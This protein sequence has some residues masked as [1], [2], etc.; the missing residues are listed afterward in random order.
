MFKLSTPLA[1]S[2]ILPAG[3]LPSAEVGISEYYFIDI[4]VFGTRQSAVPE[5]GQHN[6]LSYSFRSQCN[7]STAPL[8]YIPKKKSH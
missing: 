4:V 5:C 2:K 8:V 6:T 7:E 3:L 1:T